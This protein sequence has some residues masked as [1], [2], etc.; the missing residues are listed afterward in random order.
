MFI[1]TIKNHTGRTLTLVN[2][3]HRITIPPE[4]DVT[5]PRTSSRDAGMAVASETVWVPMRET[6][7][8]PDQLPD[9]DGTIYVFPK[10]VAL[11]LPPGLDHVAYP[12]DQVPGEEGAYRALSFPINEPTVISGDLVRDES[13]RELWE[14]PLT[15]RTV[16]DAKQEIVASWD[17]SVIELKIEGCVLSTSPHAD[18]VAALRDLRGHPYAVKTV[19]RWPSDVPYLLVRDIAIELERVMGI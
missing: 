9:D 8:D 1:N 7:T 6:W 4:R 13:D 3:S 16:G 10:D 14:I 19:G 11:T 18:F 12:D 2:G 17:G 5:M 15:V